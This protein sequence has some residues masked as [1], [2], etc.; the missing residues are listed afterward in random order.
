MNYEGLQDS[1]WKTQIARITA[2]RERIAATVPSLPGRVVPEDEDLVIGQGRRLKMAV[3]FLD[4]SDFSGRLSETEEEQSLLLKVLNLFFTEMI[5]ISEEYGGTVEKNTGDGLMAYFEDGAGT[6]Q[7]AGCKRALACA[8]TMMSTNEYLIKPILDATPV[9]EIKFRV[10]ID[11]GYVTVA[12][13]GAARRF[14]ANVAIGAAANF[15]SKMLA[16]ADPGDIVIGETVRGQLPQ[17]WHQFAQPVPSS[18]GW[19]YRQSGLPYP[20]YK[21]TGRWFATL[22]AILAFLNSQN[23]PARWLKDVRS[24]SFVDFLGFLSMFGLAAGAITLLAGVFPRLR[25]SRRG[26]LFFGAIAECDSSGHYVA[27]VLA[28]SGD[29][30]VLAKL[31]HCHELSKVCCAKYRTL[32]A[33]FWI[34]CI[35][36]ASSL[37]FLLLAKSIAA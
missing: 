28:R 5:R 1:Y 14:N 20:L 15:A 16:H 22:T 17:A 7:E 4:I 23:T 24:W 30:L 2:L 27:D 34:G 3:S 29:D 26:I 25:G 21:Y 31:E 35:G 33:G 13:L 11:Y 18:T 9:P 10:S 19:T 12:R 6:P 32:R 8:L 37:L 36:V